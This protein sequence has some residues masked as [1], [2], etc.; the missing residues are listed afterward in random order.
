[1]EMFFA[2]CGRHIIL[3]SLLTSAILPSFVMHYPRLIVVSRRAIRKHKHIDY[4]FEFHLDL[5]ALHNG[6]PI[7][8]PCVAGFLSSLD[9][10]S[11]ID[12]LLLAVGEGIGSQ[13]AHR[14]LDNTVPIQPA[15]IS[16][17][18]SNATT[19][20]NKDAIEFSLVCRCLHDSIPIFSV[21]SACLLS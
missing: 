14:A 2:Y 5:W 16:K 13:F 15:R 21:T 12:G 11:P 3:L 6:L 10:L 4:D 9:S 17:H 18:P 1:M 20:T 7:I 8:V 19:D